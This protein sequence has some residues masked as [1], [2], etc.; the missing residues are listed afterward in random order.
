M[1]QPE[2]SL[3]G[4]AVLPKMGH[5]HFGDETGLPGVLIF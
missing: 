1:E 3:C 4:Y 5:D 2:W